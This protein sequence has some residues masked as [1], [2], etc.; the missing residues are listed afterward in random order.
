MTATPE[1]ALNRVNTNSKPSELRITDMRVA[2]IVGAP[3]TL[4]AAQDLHQ[5][6][7]RRPG[8]GA[9]RRQRH[10][11]A[12][13]E[14][15]AAR[16]E[17]LRHRPAVPPHQAV[18]RPRPAGRRRLGGRDRA[19]G[20]R[21]QGLRRADLPDARRQVPRQGAHATA[22]PTPTSRAAPRP[23]S[24]SRSAWTC[25]FTFLKMDLGLMQIADV[26]GAV[27]APAGVARGLPASIPAAARSRRSRTAA[28][29]T[30]PTTSTTSATRSPACTSPTRG[31]TCSSS[32]SPR[33]A[34]SSATEIPLAIDHVGHISLQNGI[35]LARRIEKYAPAWLEDVIPWQYTDQY[36]QLQE[37]TIGADLHRRGHLPQG[38]LRAAA[39]VPASR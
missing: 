19:V 8:R 17:P 24:A 34:R 37:A 26:P 25:G 32:T 22:T 9:R 16:R 39:Q 11:C 1:D 28:H 33:S 35:R 10:L 23:A 36:R 5:P 14:E 31:S 4:G 12:D 29:A 2:E 20:P 27:V 6:G 13:A 18:R 38:R 7:H 3:F 30:P 15:P 21:G